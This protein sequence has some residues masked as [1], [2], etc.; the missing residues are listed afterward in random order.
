MLE[1]IVMIL[2]DEIN[3]A[4]AWTRDFKDEVAAATSLANLQSRVAT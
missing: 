3:I 4:R 2:K 1:I